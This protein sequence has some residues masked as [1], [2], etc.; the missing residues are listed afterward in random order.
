MLIKHV[1]W[2]N[3]NLTGD[4]SGEVNLIISFYFE[5]VSN[6]WF[7]ILGYKKKKEKRKRK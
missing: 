7:Q 3:C 5:R 6:S 2:F 4:Q 1:Y